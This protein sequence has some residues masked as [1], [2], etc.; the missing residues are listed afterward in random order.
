[1]PRL[2]GVNF[3]QGMMNSGILSAILIGGEGVGGGAEKKKLRQNLQVWTRF[4][5]KKEGLAEGTI[6]KNS[7]SS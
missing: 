3:T 1:M 6:S 2:K 5:W 4:A 7:F